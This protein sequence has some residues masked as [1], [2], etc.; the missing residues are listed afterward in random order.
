[1]KVLEKEPNKV[2]VVQSPGVQS[3]ER[4]VSEKDGRVKKISFLNTV[5]VLWQIQEIM[6]RDLEQMPV[7]R[8]QVQP[9]RVRVQ[10]GFILAHCADC[11]RAGFITVVPA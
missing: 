6:L 8:P 3:S 11:F 1:M 7:G 5:P 4:T 10:D 2:C 9:F